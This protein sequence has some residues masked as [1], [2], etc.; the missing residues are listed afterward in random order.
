MKGQKLSRRQLQRSKSAGCA[1]TDSRRLNTDYMKLDSKGWLS[2]KSAK[3]IQVS[4]VFGCFMPAAFRA[5]GQDN[6]NSGA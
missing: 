3:K 4:R 1:E 6:K 5:R 2:E